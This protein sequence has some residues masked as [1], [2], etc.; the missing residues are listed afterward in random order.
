[1]RERQ[2]TDR[3]MTLIEI[4]VVVAIVGIV[5]TMTISAMGSSTRK[6]NVNNFLGTFA[7]EITNARWAA[8]RRGCPV[9]L[10]L[11]SDGKQVELRAYAEPGDTTID[12]TAINTFPLDQAGIVELDRREFDN[13][14]IVPEQTAFQIPMTFPFQGLHSSI[15]TSTTGCTFCNVYGSDVR[16][17]V[18]VQP[19][20][21]VQIPG[22]GS[23]GGGF[24]YA[25][26]TVDPSRR[27]GA[28]GVLAPSGMVRV[29]TY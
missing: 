8:A 27:Y 25:T 15:P 14:A 17:G 11:S 24:I 21:Q 2:N 1:M 5:A 3:G 19:D 16:G 7:A 20:G 18:R 4:M 23:F 12:L 6:A 26:P 9:V 29:F 10:V 13:T 22:A 28:V